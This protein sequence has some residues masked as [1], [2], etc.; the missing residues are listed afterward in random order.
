M[1]EDPDAEIVPAVVAQLAAKATFAPL[2][3][4]AWLPSDAAQ[5]AAV[6]GTLTT[7]LTF[8]TPTNQAHFEGVTAALRSALGDAVAEC[9]VPP[10]PPAA[11]RAAPA[12]A[13]AAA[14]AWRS[15]TDLLAAVCTF[16]GVLSP[17]VLTDLV[18]TQLL[19][20]EIQ[21]AI[22]VAVVAAE[23]GCAF[24]LSLIHI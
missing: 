22:D 6:R 3:A 12:A 7:L 18:D 4:E 11:L 20:R 24:S 1:E 2:L 10:W 13:V 14:A 17:A 21:P 23:R 16:Q 19:G 9:R 15:A 5:A 8:A